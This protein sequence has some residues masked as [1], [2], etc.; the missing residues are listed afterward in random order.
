MQNVMSNPANMLSDPYRVRTGDTLTGIAKRS[1]R[2]LAELK[3]FNNLADA[4][5]LK[6]GQTLY[7]S[8]ATAFG[9]SVLFLDSLRHPIA[10]LP[11]RLHFDGRTLQGL[12]DETGAILN[13]VTQSAR[14]QVEVWVKNADNQWQQIANTASG[15][16]H[17]LITAVS[18]FFVVKGQTEK[19]P[20]GAPPKPASE[21][22]AK[23]EKTKPVQA[24]PPKPAQGSPSANNPAVKTRPK[25][26]P[27]GQSVIEIGIDL[28]QGLMALFQQ[29]TGEKITEGDW[30]DSAEQ[31]KCEVEV[32]K[33]IAEVE[34][35]GAAF[36]KL[37][38][39]DKAGI[40][41]AILFERHY[42]HRLTCANGP[43]MNTK[44]RQY[45][46]IGVAGCKSPH[47]AF[48]DL[49]YPVA[50]V[51]RKDKTGQATLGKADA[52]MPSGHVEVADQYG[53]GAKSYLRLLNAYRLNPDAALKSCSWGMFQIM[54]DEHLGSCGVTD[55]RDFVKTMCS[56]EKGQLKMLQQFVQHK[57]GGKLLTAVRA[58]D[59]AKIAYYYNGP[60]YQQNRYDEKM[61]NAY[62]KL[63]NL[64]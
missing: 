56:G 32:L 12:T 5:R 30:R 63:K 57:A 2:T 20:T 17:K 64:A 19:L 47:D 31:L 7:L 61:E 29:Y 4:N 60:G 3:R 18:A 14:S 62:K 39:H 35:K 46:G 23:S 25:K 51:A 16:G 53:D 15:Y 38:A 55:V 27:Q 22:Q 6:V 26:G 40:V 52:K 54:G 42:F 37:N 45:H 10:N 41:P 13:K 33:A 43:R 1:G 11:Y 50:F 21:P 8:E 44:D 49:C 48:H 59:W 24:P 58:K 9:I 28:P 36:W 34:S